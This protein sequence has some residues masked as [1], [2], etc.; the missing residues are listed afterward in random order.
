VTD[1]PRYVVTVRT[2]MS[3]VHRNPEEQCNLDDSERDKPVDEDRALDLVQRGE[4]RTCGHCWR[5]MD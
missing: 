3:T 5:D 1:E 2:G 4:A